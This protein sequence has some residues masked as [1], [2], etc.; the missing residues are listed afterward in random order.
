M[1]LPFPNNAVYSNGPTVSEQRCISDTDVTLPPLHG[2]DARPHTQHQG[3]SFGRHCCKVVRLF[4]IRFG[5][6]E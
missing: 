1:D 4:I 6:R 2:R 3:S 5:K